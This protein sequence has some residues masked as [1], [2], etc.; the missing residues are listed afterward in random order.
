MADEKFLKLKHTFMKKTFYWKNEDNFLKGSF[1]NTD[2]MKT[3]IEVVLE[4][5][6]TSFIAGFSLKH[7]HKLL[8][9]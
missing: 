2:H 3:D 5:I 1:G 9:Q 7:T 6:P 4:S 8:H